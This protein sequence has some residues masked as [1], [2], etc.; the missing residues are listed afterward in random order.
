MQ[1]GCSRAR[2]RLG[3]AT[4]LALL[5]AGCGG[6]AAPSAT[7]AATPVPTSTVAPTSSASAITAT[8]PASGPA[9]TAGTTGKAFLMT[10]VLPSF[11]EV[12]GG[13]LDPTTF[14]DSITDDTPDVFVV[15]LLG[16]GVNGAIDSTWTDTD[17][18]ASFTHNTAPLAYPGTGPNWEWDSSNVAG[19][20]LPAGHYSVVFT[21]EPTGETATVPFTITPTPGESTA[22]PTASP[23]GSSGA[24][25]FTIAGLT[26]TVV[27]SAPSIDTSAFATSFPADTAS[28]YAEFALATG[29]GGDV[30]VTWTSGAGGTSSNSITYGTDP[31]AWFGATVTGR[32]TPGTNTATLTYVP[33]GQSI[34]LPFAITA[35]TGSPSTSAEPSA[36][37]TFSLL[38]TASAGDPSA[39][40]PDP[41]TFT[42]TFST[43]DPS[44][45]VIFELADGLTGTV[46][47]TVSEGGTQVVTPFSMDYGPN[48]SWGSFEVD[49]GTGFT[50]GDYEATV[51][52]EPTGDTATVDFTVQ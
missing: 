13:N 26:S 52:F 28:V 49:A 23:S 20:W 41:S 39:S 51:T 9:G 4:G 17:S 8:P 22:A 11:P 50:A 14:V 40:A 19:G 3:L 27:S 36:T 44:V 10:G 45:Y 34:S 1:P 16:A 33:T 21:F 6:A 24:S 2:R 7:P 5:V 32:F 47:C 18:G 35:A 31:W 42:D 25:P 46:T 15:Y 30:T 38:K 43:S 12:V 29:F 48:N 37:G